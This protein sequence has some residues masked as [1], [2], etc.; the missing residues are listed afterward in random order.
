[1][2]NSF[3][4]TFIT[5]LSLKCKNVLILSLIF[6]STLLTACSSTSVSTP[7]AKVTEQSQPTVPVTPTTMPTATPIPHP[8]PT[9]E[10]TRVYVKAQPTSPPPVTQPSSAPAILDLQPA[11][12]SI[13][14][15]LDCK[16]TTT[17]TC[18]ARVLS[19][20]D[21]Q[22]ALNWSAFTNVPGGITFSP[23]SGA[24]APGQSI[25]VTIIVPT[26]ACTPGLFFFRGPINTHTITW[27]C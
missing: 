12:M 2:Q 13:V 19:R 10:A 22:S 16:K 21:N 11:S 14:G 4:K 3:Y 7:T 5:F 25:L 18:F 15:H 24:L 17:F 8:K 1:M 23:A 6:I 20:S 27:A 9:H 26:N